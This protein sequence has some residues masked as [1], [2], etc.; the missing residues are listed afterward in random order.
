MKIIVSLDPISNGTELA[1]TSKSDLLREMAQGTGIKIHYI[2]DVE[3]RGE[4]SLLP[5]RPPQPEH[6]VTINYTS[7]TT[8]NPKGV[9]LLHSNAVAA[10]SASMCISEQTDGD[11]ICSYLPLAHI[12]ERITEGLALWAGAAIGYFHGNILELVDDL[13]LLR[14]TSFISVP[15][16][17]N[18]FGGV[19]KAQTVEQ[20]GIKGA[21]SRHVVSTKLANLEHAAPGKATNKHAIYD[22]IWAKKVAAALGLERARTVISGSAP[23]DP[24][25]HQ[26]L[27]GVLA[28]NFV[29]GY[30]LTETYAVALV[31]IMGDLSAGNCGAVSPATEICLRDVPDMEYYSTDKPHPRGEVLIRGPTVFKEYYKNPEETQKAI[32]EDGWFCSGDIATVDDLGRFKIIDRKKNVL[33]LAQGEYISPERIENV[34]LAY[35]PYLATAYVHGDSSQSN[36]VAIFGLAP[37]LFSVFVSKILGKTIGPT[38]IFELQLAAKDPNVQKAVAKEL[39]EVGKKAKLNKY[40]NAAAFRILVDPFSID[41]GLLTPT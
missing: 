4:K 2:G 39:K 17:F 36:L 31:Q 14:P 28:N 20:A 3:I 8:G 1:G 29:Q 7:G 18:R 10:M 25:L 40:E 41:N 13:K 27:C 16:L 15:R 37:D 33:K 21:L 30:G 26:F 11:V 19:I 9:T 23:I 12:Y 32:T 5:A 24:T 22:R 6:I 38:Q 35:L 34:Y